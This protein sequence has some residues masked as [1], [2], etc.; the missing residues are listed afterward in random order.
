MAKIPI[1]VQ[2]KKEARVLALWEQGKTT[3]QIAQILADELPPAVGGINQSSVSRWL[4]P[5]REMTRDAAG[6]AFQTRVRKKFD[7]DMEGVEQVQQFLFDEF[8]DEDKGI[9]DRRGFGL[10]F[11]RVTLD[12]IK[13]AMGQPQPPSEKPAGADAES[14][15]VQDVVRM[16]TETDCGSGQTSS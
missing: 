8:S 10:D 7:T 3:T 13:I 14:A 2:Y 16:L 1:I 12:K 11:V 5:Y 15:M 4:R 9:G 6:E